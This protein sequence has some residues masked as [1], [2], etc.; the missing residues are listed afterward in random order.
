MYEYVYIYIYMYSCIHLYV[1][2][3]LQAGGRPTAAPPCCPAR[4]SGPRVC[5]ALLYYMILCYYVML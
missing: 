3:E 1:Y 5:P 2:V 4:G